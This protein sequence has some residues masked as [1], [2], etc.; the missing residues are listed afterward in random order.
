MSLTCI[1][2]AEADDLL[3][4]TSTLDK[5]SPRC[6]QTYGM[7]CGFRA[8]SQHEQQPETSWGESR[9]GTSEASFEFLACGGSSP[10]PKL[11]G[12]G[13]RHAAR[14]LR[15]SATDH[16]F[17][18]ALNRHRLFVTALAAPSVLGLVV[19]CQLPAVRNLGKRSPAIHQKSSRKPAVADPS[20]L[21]S[22]S[23]HGRV[24]SAWAISVT[25]SSDSAPHRTMIVPHR[26]GISRIVLAP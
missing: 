19:R 5:V 15:C 25:F 1:T 20:E 11:Q 21:S 26:L 17:R 14:L 16:L 4:R 18:S 9:R 24:L 6:Q 10:A 3:Q 7:I 23:R 13:P 22:G 8:E 2:T 12:T